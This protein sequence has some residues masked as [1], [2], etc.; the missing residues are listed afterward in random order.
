MPYPVSAR[1]VKVKAKNFG[2]LPNWHQGA[3]GD[4]FIFIDEITIK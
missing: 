1:Y 2:T 3:G 4:A